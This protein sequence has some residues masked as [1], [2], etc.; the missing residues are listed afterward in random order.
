VVPAGAG[1]AKKGEDQERFR[2]HLEPLGA[3]IF[4]TP[5]AFAREV[6]GEGR[7]PAARP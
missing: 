7:A 5:E 4:E 6:L 3:R 1:W 2:A